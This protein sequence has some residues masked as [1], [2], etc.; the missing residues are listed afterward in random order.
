[1]RRWMTA[2]SLVA[3]TVRRTFESFAHHRLGVFMPVL[4]LLFLLAGALWVINTL[5]P[6]APVVYTLF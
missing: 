6:L 1:M 3:G 2:L 4:V 5:A